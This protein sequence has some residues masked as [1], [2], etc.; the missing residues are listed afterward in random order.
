MQV[1][2]SPATESS[3]RDKEDE[4]TED[5]YAFTRDRNWLGCSA[6]EIKAKY[7]HS[8]VTLDALGPLYALVD[9]GGFLVP[10]GTA[11]YHIFVTGWLN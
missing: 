7:V 5:L 2:D 9:R 3:H 10:L 1:D 6:D 11:R 8:A 4:V